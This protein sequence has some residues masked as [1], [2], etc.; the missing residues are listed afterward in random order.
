ML[1]NLNG[2]GDDSLPG[3]PAAQPS[4]TSPQ[5]S[6]SLADRLLSNLGERETW[7]SNGVKIWLNNPTVSVT[8]SLPDDMAVEALYFNENVIE[9]EFPN[10]IERKVDNC[11]VGAKG[12]TAAGK[13]MKPAQIEGGYNLQVP[14]FISAGDMIRVDTRTRDYIERA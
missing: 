4:D 10:L 12:N 8:I 6:S 3:T 2:C 7:P 1:M 9:L 13:V 5:V 14:L 11:D